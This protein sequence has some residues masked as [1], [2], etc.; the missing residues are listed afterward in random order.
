MLEFTGER[1]IPG[2]VEPDL[3]NEHV[4]R[5]HFASRFAASRNVV[6]I[7]CGVGY[8]SAILAETADAVRGFDLSEEAILWAAERYRLPKLRFAAAD[9]AELPLDNQTAGLVIAFELIEHLANPEALLEE[10]RRILA[11]DGLFC[12]ST[13]NA[14]YYAA[15][16][17][18]AGPNPF[19]AREYDL[20]E[21][22]ALL[23]RH[24]PSI[25]IFG[26]SHAPALSFQ[27]LDCNLPGIARLET[28][29]SE[30]AHF[31]VAVC[32]IQP[33][34][35]ITPFV[36]V[37]AAGNVLWER[38]KHIARLE[39]LLARSLEEHSVLVGAHR[40]L[41]EELEQ[42]N[43]WAKARDADFAEKSAHVDSL[44]AELERV[45]TTVRGLEADFAART[46]WALKLQAA[47][48]AKSHDL[49][50]TLDV[51]HA[52]EAERDERTHWALSLDAQLQGLATQ[53]AAATQSRWLRLGRLLGLGP[54]LTP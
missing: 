4:S 34:P 44:L 29:A 15:S 13:P 43:A 1:V 31:Y 32:S 22:R 28:V 11:H 41:K 6:D 54:K 26:Q 38:E 48:E 21:F 33:L 20:A 47:L 10:S 49:L 40:G 37:P 52:T 14:A 9:C 25:A 45:T 23:S 16:R 50:H 35:E 36:Y 7:G 19:H 3:W 42:A 24:Y 18:T 27:S 8:G 5:Y 30:Q 53:L 39:E 17:G 46:E 51:L 2:E 12:V